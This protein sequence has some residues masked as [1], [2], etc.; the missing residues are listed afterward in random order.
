MFRRRFLRQAFWLGF[1]APVFAA[2]DTDWPLWRAFVAGFMQ[3][4]GRVIDHAAG[5][6]ST[7]EGQAYAMF[8]ALVANDRERFRLLLDW[9]RRN[10][11]GDD[12]SRQLPAWLWGKSLLGRWQVLDAN[13]AS[14]ADLWLAYVLIEAG[15]LWDEPGYSDLG[16]ALL[17][18]AAR[19]CVA[20]LPGFGAM[21]LP[22]SR[23]FAYSGRRWR[24]NPSYLVPQQLRLFSLVDPQ[25]PWAEMDASLPALMKAVA[26][27]GI[28]PDWALYSAADGWLP[29]AESNAV[30]S[31]DAVRAYLWTGMVADGDPLRGMLL[32]TQRGLR[33][34]LAPGGQFPERINARTGAASGNAPP[35]F[36]AA[37]LPWLSVLGERDALAAQQR[38]LAAAKSGEL[39]GTT[40]SYYDQALA[41]FGLGWLDGRYRFGPQGRLLTFWAQ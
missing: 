33:E 40:R 29:D 17:A 6:R 8:F 20:T 12:L 1:A 35:G 34:R 5:G 21:L 37:V 18:R 32:G 39:Y 9:T 7:S 4:D 36:S 23:G 16:L 41:L 19:L 27:L 30:S 13:S 22:A 31:Y 25:G 3:A 38:R 15:R 24:I 28:V 11:A 14:D 2:T 10:L 26:P